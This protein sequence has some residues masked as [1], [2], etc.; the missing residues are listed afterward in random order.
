MKSFEP[1][2]DPLTKKS[3]VTKDQQDTTGSTGG[4]CLLLNI[5]PSLSFPPSLFYFFLF[6]YFTFLLNKIH[7]TDIWTQGLIYTFQQRRLSIINNTPHCSIKK[8]P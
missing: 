3:R 6:L 2:R 5:S 7:I 4:D 1:P 8:G